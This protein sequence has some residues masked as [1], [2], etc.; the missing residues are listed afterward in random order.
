MLILVIVFWVSYR[1]EN[2]ERNNYLVK[3]FFFKEREGVVV[4]D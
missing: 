1:L 3:I 2:C 4:S